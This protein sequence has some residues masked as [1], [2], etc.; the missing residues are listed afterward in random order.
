MDIV[1]LCG[2]WPVCFVFGMFVA[3]WLPLVLDEPTCQR[4][5]QRL[6]PVLWRFHLDWGEN[7]TVNHQAVIERLE[8][9][10]P[11]IPH[12]LASSSEDGD[13][14]DWQMVSETSTPTPPSTSPRDGASS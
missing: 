11:A 4:L 7:R 1:C 10:L 13:P 3:Y 8:Q 2:M 6:R 9:D 5:R 12:E 14:G